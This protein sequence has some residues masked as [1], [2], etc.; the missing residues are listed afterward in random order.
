MWFMK[1]WF[2]YYLGPPPPP[3]SLFW[4]VDCGVSQ[5]VSFRGL[6]GG[7]GGE[8]VCSAGKDHKTREN[9]ELKITEKNLKADCSVTVSRVRQVSLLRGCWE[10][11]QKKGQWGRGQSR[12]YKKGQGGGQKW[13]GT[14]SGLA[15]RKVFRGNTSVHPGEGSQHSIRTKEGLEKVLKIGG[16]GACHNGGEIIAQKELT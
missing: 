6:G 12:G 9:L 2:R 7:G 16:Q 15:K 1:G 5:L 13:R 3:L 4:C 8:C 10:R 11:G 14:R